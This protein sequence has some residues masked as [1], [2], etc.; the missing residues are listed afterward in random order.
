MVLY[1]G[2]AIMAYTK[3]GSMLSRTTYKEIYYILIG[4]DKI[5]VHFKKSVFRLIFLRFIE[6]EFSIAV[7][8]AMLRM[9]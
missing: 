6:L 8:M 2:Y 4:I 5:R 9:I 3:Q 1:L 7:G